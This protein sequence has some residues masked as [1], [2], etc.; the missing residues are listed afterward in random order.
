M[1]LTPITIIIGSV[2]LFFSLLFYEA[3][4]TAVG[5]HRFYFPLLFCHQ[6]QSTLPQSFCNQQ[7]ILTMLLTA[8]HSRQNNGSPKDGFE[9]VNG[10]LYVAKGTVRL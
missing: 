10:L 8:T 5:R 7:T 1:D 3:F 2:V 9:P 4:H 6:H